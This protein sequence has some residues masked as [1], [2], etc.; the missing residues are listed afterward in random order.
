M[1]QQSPTAF[2]HL[3]QLG[4]QLAVAW[5]CRSEKYL[6]GLPFALTIVVAT[7]S[8]NVARCSK[9][10]RLSSGRLRLAA[11]CTARR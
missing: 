7:G 11:S 5:P 8:R 2:D 4:E 10:R 6:N 3:G 9:S 1:T